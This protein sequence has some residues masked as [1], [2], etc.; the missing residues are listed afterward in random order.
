M[1]FDA[2]LK[3]S[4]E[5]MEEFGVKAPDKSTLNNDAATSEPTPTTPAAIRRE[6]STPAPIDRRPGVGP[7][8]L[9]AL[10][11][12]NQYDRLMRSYDADPRFSVLKGNGKK[13]K[14]E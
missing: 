3:R 11:G 7:A 5:R 4:L 14:P 1:D 10:P 12:E 13:Y 2:L 9:P 6:P 8:I